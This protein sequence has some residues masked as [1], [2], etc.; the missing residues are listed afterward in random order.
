M[1]AMILSGGVEADGPMAW[2]N[3]RADTPAL[4]C[5]VRCPADWH[6]DF[7]RVCLKMGSSTRDDQFT[8]ENDD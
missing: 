4:G 7:S 2:Q 3:G 8:R 1:L 5:S 6:A